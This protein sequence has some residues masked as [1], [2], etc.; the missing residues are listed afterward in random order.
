MASTCGRSCR[1]G[2]PRSSVSPRAENR[3]VKCVTTY[4]CEMDL[5][6]SG[7]NMMAASFELSPETSGQ[8]LLC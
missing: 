6:G 3:R 8:L 7:Q 4:E 2:P 5:T 1:C